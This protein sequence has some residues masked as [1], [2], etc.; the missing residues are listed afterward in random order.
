[1]FIFLDEQATA[2][3]GSLFSGGNLFFWISIVL[4]IAV[5]YFLVIRP[6]KKQEREA[7]ELKSSLQVGDEITTI[8]GIVG[9]VVRVKE[10]IFTIVT[11]KERTRI[12]FQRSA[13]RSI[14]RRN[15]EPYSPAPQKSKTDVKKDADSDKTKEEKPV[16]EKKSENGNN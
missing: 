4:V 11:S 13:L 8:G 9:I 16:E 15:G 14:D 12:T 5:F 10:D 7:N 1:M 2:G 3:S 6:Q